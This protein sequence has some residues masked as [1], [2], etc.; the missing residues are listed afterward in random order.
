MGHLFQS[1]QP[2]FA[3]LHQQGTRRERSLWVDASTYLLGAAFFDWLDRKVIKVERLSS[4]DYDRPFRV[5]E[6]LFSRSTGEENGV[7][8]HFPSYTEIVTSISQLQGEIRFRTPFPRQLHR[9]VDQYVTTARPTM[10][11]VRRRSRFLL[12]SSKR[13]VLTAWRILPP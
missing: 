5:P 9:S 3:V 4:L 12:I 8:N 6:Q 2:R 7:Q 1:T 11:P 10:S 13:M